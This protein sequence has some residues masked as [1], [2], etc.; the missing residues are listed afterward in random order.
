MIAIVLAATYERKL[1]ARGKEVPLPLLDLHGEPYLTTLVKKLAPLPGLAGILVVTND[2]LKPDLDAWASS[3]PVQAKVTVLGDGTRTPEDRLGAVGDVIFG[4]K[5]AQVDDDLLVIGGDNWFAYDLGEFVGRSAERSPAVVVTPLPAGVDPSRFGVADLDAAGRIRSFVEKPTANEKWPLR[6][7]CIYYFAARDLS[8]FDTFAQE[9]PTR[10]SPGEFISWLSGR[11]SVYGVRME[12]TWYD[13]AGTRPSRLKGPDALE[14]RQA[15]RRS[16]TPLN[17]PWER[18]AARQIQWVGSHQD[19][20][21][22]L[23]DSDPNKRILAAQLL[24]NTGHL[25]D[26]EGQDEVMK[27]LVRLL[28]DGQCHQQG[29]GGSDDEDE[30]VY[31]RDVTAK[32]L[33]KLGYGTSREDVFAKYRQI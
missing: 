12:A 5:S 27:G 10:C 3:L 2:V 16:V 25:L 7:S 29:Y 20:L 14:F 23:H 8:W 6:A 11:A 26:A 31:V 24:G 4:L 28:D 17:E 33:V 30:A 13:L 19:L 21:E 1:D 22:V 18:A 15:L 9:H 32:A